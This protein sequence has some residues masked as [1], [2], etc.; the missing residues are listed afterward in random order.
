LG[1]PHG[2][3]IPKGRITEDGP[4]PDIYNLTEMPTSSHPRRTKKNIEESD[5]TLILTHGTLTGRSE[6]TKI[7]ALKYWKPVLHIDLNKTLPTYA[8]AEICNWITEHEIKVLNVTGSR[9][10]EDPRIYDAA[11]GIIQDVYSIRLTEHHID[12]SL[13]FDSRWKNQEHPADMPQTVDEAIEDII[14]DMDLS[15]KV[16]LANLSEEDLVPLQLSLGLYI[17]EK[18]KIWSVNEALEQSYIEACREEAL[19]ES[20]PAAVIITKI[21]KK[22]RET[23]KLR[24]V[25]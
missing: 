20:N 2:G 6:Y 5:G 22:L 12:V 1:I 13:M 7:W 19:D 8:T 11:F 10:S 14:G 3:W 16:A 4:L 24:V 17:K 21:W 23:H 15:N 25:E 9:A 18:L